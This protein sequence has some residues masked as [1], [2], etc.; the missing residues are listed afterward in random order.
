MK[1]LLPS[2][3]GDIA[4]AW[5][6]LSAALE[7]GHFAEQG[8]DVELCADNPRGCEEL[9]GCL[10]GVTSVTAG[11]H[12][13]AQILA[14]PIEPGTRFD[15]LQDPVHISTDHWFLGG[16][17]IASWLPD[18]PPRYHYPVALPETSRAFAR[19]VGAGQPYGVLYPSSID[20]QHMTD[21]WGAVWSPDDW[22]T[23]IHALELRTHLPWYAVGSAADQSMLN[24]LVQRGALPQERV[25][26]PASLLDTLALIDQAAYFCGFPAGPAVLAAVLGT[27]HCVPFR[28]PLQ[29][30]ARGAFTD[31]AMI[32]DGRAY[33]PW[34][35][36]DPAI[37]A[38]EAAARVRAFA[39]EPARPG[40]R[41]VTEAPLTPSSFAQPF[42]PRSDLQGELA[43][44]ISRFRLN[45]LGIIARPNSRDCFDFAVPEDTHYRWLYAL[46][47]H[48]R[49]RTLFE[50]GVDHGHGICALLWGVLDEGVP[51]IAVALADI[52][53]LE[54]AQAMVQMVCARSS[55]RPD[56]RSCQGPGKSTAVREQLGMSSYEFIHL[57]ASRDRD[58]C[59]ADARFAYNC[60][61]APGTLALTGATLPGVGAAFRQLCV[62]LGI[63]PVILPTCCGLGIIRKL[64]TT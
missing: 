62:E 37:A 48:Y 44:H 63:E 45:S 34:F 1:L 30:L 2:G 53:S 14:S 38:A 26:R 47:R 4:A 7:S 17:H 58:E 8:Y 60:L 46:G 22:R 64:S 42:A 32:H 11:R 50:I 55:F 51:P 31:P 41:Y 16:R 19:R 59:L 27:P 52:Q 33:M 43:Q 36:T 23:F 61:A 25:L 40:A 24:F 39:L 12:T 56:V 49:P 10:P 6:K 9:A 54:Y 28:Y 15:S 5:I 35:T 57:D 29:R 3:F 20:R 18:L 21:G 13:T